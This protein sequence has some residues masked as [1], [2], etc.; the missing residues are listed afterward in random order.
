M[1]SSRLHLCTANSIRETALP[2]S[3]SEVSSIRALQRAPA[4]CSSAAREISIVCFDG[5]RNLTLQ[6][7]IR[8]SSPKVGEI[9]LIE[10]AI[11]LDM[12]LRFCVTILILQPHLNVPPELIILGE[13]RYHR[14]LKNPYRQY[15]FPK[16]IFQH[17]ILI[18]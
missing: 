1:L 13:D 17:T 18:R 10:Y 16:G 11:D 8:W 6:T 12:E 9:F 15:E 14:D 3:A 2:D 5:H 7:Y 4:L